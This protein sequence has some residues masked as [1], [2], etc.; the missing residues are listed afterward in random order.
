MGQ[1]TVRCSVVQCL[2]NKSSKMAKL[3]RGLHENLEISKLKTALERAKAS[4]N[5]GS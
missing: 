1:T 3:G 5:L 4:D 2:Q